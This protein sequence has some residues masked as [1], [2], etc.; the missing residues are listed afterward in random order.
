MAAPPTFRIPTT[1]PSPFLL[2]KCATMPKSSPAS[3][4]LAGPFC[5]SIHLAISIT[6]L[7]FLIRWATS[8]SWLKPERIISPMQRKDLRHAYAQKRMAASP[9]GNPTH[10]SP[11]AHLSTS[12]SGGALIRRAFTKKIAT[13][14]NASLPFTRMRPSIIYSSPISTLKILGDSKTLTPSCMPNPSFCASR[15]PSHETIPAPHRPCCA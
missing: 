3:T 8:S 10:P 5:A 13:H 1:P 6:G 2:L 4:L 14:P 9:R 12:L 15:N 7:C 11:P